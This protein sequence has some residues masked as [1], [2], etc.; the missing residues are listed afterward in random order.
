MRV[1]DQRRFEGE[2]APSRG[3]IVMV[4]VDFSHACMPVHARHPQMDG[5]SKTS[6]LVFVMAASNLPWT[7]DPAMLRRLEKRVR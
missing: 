4:F 5:L 3:L 7:L 1:R 6:D 2:P